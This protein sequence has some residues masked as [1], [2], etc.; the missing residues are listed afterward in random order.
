M[1]DRDWT[2][3]ITMAAPE[4]LARY[5]PEMQA[6]IKRRLA[7]CPQ[8]GMRV[9]MVTGEPTP[10]A[11]RSAA[12]NSAIVAQTLATSAILAE[13][14]RAAT[15]QAAGYATG[16]NDMATQL[17]ADGTPAAEAVEQITT[18]PACPLLGI[19]EIMAPTPTDYP[20]SG[21]V[22]GYRW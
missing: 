18:A 3:R 8:R 21:G 9:Y 4:V 14:K 12:E 7:E 1:F 6:L 15:I 2:E 19:L 10:A 17:I 16:R 11:A 13:R 20:L 5:S 22:P